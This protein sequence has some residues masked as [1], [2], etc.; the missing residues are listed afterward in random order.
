MIVCHCARVTDVALHGVIRGGAASVQE[1]VQRTGAGNHCEP[2]REEIAALLAE[3][4]A[5]SVPLSD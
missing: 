1:I 2:C 5:S 3:Y 4:Q